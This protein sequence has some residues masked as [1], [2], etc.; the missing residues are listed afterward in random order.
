MGELVY[1]APSTAISVAVTPIR[2][3]CVS[4]NCAAQLAGHLGY[5]FLALQG[6]QCNSKSEPEKRI[7][8]LVQR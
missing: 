5:R 8:Q 3:V 4:T 6:L 7:T 2:A 1:S